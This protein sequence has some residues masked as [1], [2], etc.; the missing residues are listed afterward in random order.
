MLKWRF[1]ER[2]NHTVVHSVSSMGWILQNEAHAGEV[3]SGETEYSRDARIC[4]ASSDFTK[5]QSQQILQL[6]TD[7]S[8][9]FASST[10]HI[11]TNK[12]GDEG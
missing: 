9:A 11:D 12:E 3:K 1:G 6:V 8:R 2:R 5:Q 7:L 4:R 10:D